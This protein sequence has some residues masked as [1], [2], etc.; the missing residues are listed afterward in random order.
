MTD[1]GSVCNDFW[2]VHMKYS[3]LPPFP[4]FI[5][6]VQLKLK[7]AILLNTV[8]SLVAVT[9]SQQTYH[10]LP[11]SA[12]EFAQASLTETAKCAV[13]KNGLTNE[14]TVLSMSSGSE[15][16]NR[17][18]NEDS[19][20]LSIICD[21]GKE[22]DDDGNK[23]LLGN[24]KESESNHSKLSHLSSFCCKTFCNN[25]TE[26]ERAQNLPAVIDS[27]SCIDI[28]VT[29]LHNSNYM[30][31]IQSVQHNS[32]VKTESSRIQGFPCVQTQVISL[33]VER[34]IS[35]ALITSIG[36]KE[37]YSLLRNYST[38]IVD[39]CGE[40]QRVILHVISLIYVQPKVARIIRLVFPRILFLIKG[41]VAYH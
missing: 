14:N 24:C 28:Q 9:V 18:L 7:D 3:L 39:V 10:K 11:D 19:N 13:E 20:I 37:M 36:L 29:N 33:D 34:Y 23:L 41:L 15:P 21:N 5:P 22:I 31:L 40:S 2:A 27:A 26:A 1:H 25:S 30:E 12:L 6:C 17:L 4:T 38:Q 8:D 35:E 16:E 32:D